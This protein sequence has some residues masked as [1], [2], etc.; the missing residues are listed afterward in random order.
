MQRELDKGEAAFILGAGVDILIA[1]DFVNNKANLPPNWTSLITGLTPFREMT[2]FSFRKKAQLRRITE[3][4][5]TE[6]AS[7]ARWW[8]GDAG[9]RDELKRRLDVNP[10]IV[11][12]IQSDLTEEKATFQLCLLLVRSNL[13]VTSN[14]SS[15]VSKRYAHSVKGKS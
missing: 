4:W 1:L 9:F 3:T 15:Y 8:S 14:Y 6:A 11:S 5:P 10:A 13:I 12:S 7:L 2:D